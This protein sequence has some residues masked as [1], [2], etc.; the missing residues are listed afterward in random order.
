MTG[1]IPPDKDDSARGSAETEDSPTPPPPETAITHAL[2]QAGPHADDWTANEVRPPARTWRQE[3]PRWLATLD[4]QRTRREYEKAVTYFFSAPGVP[5]ALS[6]LT[7]DLLLAYRGSLALRADRQ[8]ATATTPAASD[9]RLGAATPESDA[10][11]LPHPDADGVAAEE[12]PLD[13]ASGAP[14]G[15]TTRPLAPATVNIRLTALRQFLVHLSLW[16][17]LPDLTAE[18]I[19]AAL[20]RLHIERRRPYQI[21]AEPEWA[22]FLAAART[23]RSLAGTTAASGASA[24]VATAPQATTTAHSEVAHSNPNEHA[25]AVPDL[26]ATPLDDAAQARQPGHPWGM[27]RALRLRLHAQAAQTGMESPSTPGLATSPPRDPRPRRAPEPP[28]ARAP[29][30]SRAGLTGARTAQRDHALLALALATGLRAVELCALDVGDLAREWHAG[31]ADWWLVLPDAKTKGQRGGRTLPLAPA[32]IE[33]LHEYVRATG[34]RWEDAH[35]RMTPLFLSRCCAPATPDPVDAQP[36]PRRLSTAQ[37]RRIVDRVEA[38]WIA[39][40]A[41]ASAAGEGRA[42][43]PHALRHSTALALLEGNERSAR[44]PASVEHVRGWLG[45]FDIRTTQ[46][47]LAH[48]DAR[49]HRRPFAL[50]PLPDPTSGESVP[51]DPQPAPR[52]PVTE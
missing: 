35:D 6:D 51:S 25:D 30:R 42:I 39:S 22:G 11:H 1:A 38:Q 15:A 47:Y 21:L 37:V 36:T 3:L 13:A 4:S 44:P 8:L 23:P 14:T 49:R 5:E 28:P 33:T 16:G 52:Q 2:A 41:G 10:A 34:R 12:P 19:R 48:L 26:S 7:F 29:V 32:L 18:R 17:L 20:R 24:P 46:G 31:H 40:G 50:Q 27:P 45:H 9:A 43:S